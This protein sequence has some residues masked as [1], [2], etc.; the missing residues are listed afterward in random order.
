MY[1]S[2]TNAAGTNTYLVRIGYNGEIGGITG[3]AALT[4]TGDERRRRAP[5]RSR[6]S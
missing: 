4:H 2:G 5:A 1:A 6:S 3:R